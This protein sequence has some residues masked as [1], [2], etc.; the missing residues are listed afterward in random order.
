VFESS[1]RKQ[2]IMVSELFVI[3]NMRPSLSCLRATPRFSNHY[4]VLDA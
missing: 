4:M 1:L 2:L 3:G